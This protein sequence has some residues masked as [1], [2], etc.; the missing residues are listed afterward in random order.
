MHSLVSILG[1]VLTKKDNWL[2]WSHKVKYTLIFNDL[3]VGI[4]DEDNQPTELIDTKKLIV[5]NIKNSKAFSFITATISE[6]VNY[7]INSIDDAWNEI[8]KLKQLF[9]SHS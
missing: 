6:E 5:W 4:C 9:D 8:K 1:V 3:W 2:E 7:H